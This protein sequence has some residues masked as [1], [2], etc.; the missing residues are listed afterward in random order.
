MRAGISSISV[1]E[2]AQMVVHV[3]A[4]DY[5]GIKSGA[6]GDPRVKGGKGYPTGIGWAGWLGGTLLKGANLKE[7]LLLNYVP[8]REKP[9][10]MIYRSGNY[11][12][13]GLGLGWSQCITWTLQSAMALLD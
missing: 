8:Q 11:R 1:A 7:T 10:L 12:H 6:V 13:L 4:Y 5:S 9:G 2:A 3:M